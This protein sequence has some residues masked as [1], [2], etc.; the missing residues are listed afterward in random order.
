MRF[1]TLAAAA[2][3]VSVASA[4]NI[5]V[6]VGDQQALT[7]TPNSVTAAEGDTISF[8]FL[9]KN[10]SVVQSTFADPCTRQ[11]TPIEGIS[12][13]FQ[14]VA[15]DAKAIPEWSFTVNN[16]SAALWFFCSQTNPVSHCNKGMVFAVNAK[17]GEKSFEAYQAKAMALGSTA[18]GA[19]G[20]AG[21]PGGG[22][23][24]PAGGAGGAA[25]ASQSG[26][27][28]PGASG[29]PP[30]NAASMS[31]A[32]LAGIVACAAGLFAGLLL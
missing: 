1:S 31:R 3:L 27:T 9:S 18:G 26:S 13:G 29:T 16:A 21:A 6:K 28:P 23:S 25:G 12:S 5:V 24:A 7:F 17:P 15:A 20:G 14:P 10:H 4:A 19:S 32:S 30:P 2:S 8:Q 11:A 22:A